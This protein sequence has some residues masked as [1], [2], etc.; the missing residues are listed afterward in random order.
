M[1]TLQEIL[2]KVPIEGVSGN[3]GLPI[4]EVVFDSRKVSQGALYVAQKGVHVD[5]HDFI[6]QAIEKGAHAIVCEVLP[7]ECRNECTY[8][9]V[10]NASKALGII[11]SNYYDNPSSK[12]KLVGIT[13]TNGKTSISTLLFRLFEGQGLPCGLISTVGIQYGSHAIENTHTTPDALTLNQHLAAMV[14]HGVAYC[15]MEVSSHGIAQHR[16][17]GLHFKGGIFTNLTHDHLDYHGDFKTYRDIKKIFFDHL[18]STAFALTYLDDKNGA[19]MLQNTKAKKYSY[20]LHQNADFKAQ[21]LECQF[22]G[23]LLKMQDME[24]WTHLVGGFNVQNLLAVFA[25]ARLMDLPALEVLQQ[26]SQL[27]PVKGRFQ[28]FQN[29]DQITVVV[30]YAHTPDAL[31]NVLKTINEIRTRNEKLYTVI[32]CGGNRDKEKRPIMGQI[33]AALSDKVI[34]TSDNPRDEDPAE[35]I[36]QMITGVEPQHFKKA[37]K[38]T[39]REEA[40]AMAGQLAQKGDIVL[41]AGKGHEDYQEIGGKKIPFSDME[42]A[43]KIFLKSE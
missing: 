2:Y 17:D 21:V 14:I 27:H 19:F 15:F 29:P 3:T 4:S 6:D 13:G 38:I 31:E 39:Q 7:K 32:G 8:V 40:I 33:A 25:T 24:V 34:F 36:S 16:I 9:V 22:S 28:T 20:A 10:L 5:G 11:A 1:K 41:I 42:Y 12:I 30:D 18:P 43:Q 37:L 26:I 23:M 35:I